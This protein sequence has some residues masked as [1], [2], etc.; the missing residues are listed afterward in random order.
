M[1][2]LTKEQEE[3]VRREILQKPNVTGFSAVIQKKI[4]DGRETGEEAIRIYMRKKF[5][6]EELLP[7][8]LVDAAIEGVKTDLVEVG[9]VVAH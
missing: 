6:I 2:H 3:K 8:A 1:T 9:K 4:K 7:E 5:K